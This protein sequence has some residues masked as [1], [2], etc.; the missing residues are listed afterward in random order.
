MNA[1]DKRS[2][3]AMIRMMRKAE[4]Q[5]GVWSVYN[6]ASGYMQALQNAAIAAG[7]V[8]VLDRYSRVSSVL[9]TVR[10]V[11]SC[12]AASHAICGDRFG[13]KLW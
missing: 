11:M 5:T 9:V 6:H 2:L 10:E 1:H 4:T 8:S 7:D 13:S 3:G 12:R